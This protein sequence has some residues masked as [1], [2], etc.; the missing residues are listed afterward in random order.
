[1]YLFYAWVW[2]GNVSLDHALPVCVALFVLVIVMARCA[3]KWYDMPVRLYL[4][5][6][7]NK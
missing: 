2:A 4:N 7:L 6:L 5:K 1:M 3:L